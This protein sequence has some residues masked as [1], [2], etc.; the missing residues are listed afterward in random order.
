MT[1]WNLADVV[2][3]RLIDTR[4]LPKITIREENAIAAL[5]VMS[6]FAVDPKWL[7]YLPPTMS[8]SETSKKPELLEHP[9][10]ALGY[11]RNEGV[12]Q[13]IC[14]QKHMGS[15]AVVILCRDES[16]AL[17][18]FGVLTPRAWD[19]IHSHRPSLLYRRCDRRLHS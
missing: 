8:P 14:E 9:Q 16:V 3:K 2:G 17:S 5:E 18:R 6:R 11:Y 19:G 12:S 10:E 7:M 4:L 1:P 15:R 13:V